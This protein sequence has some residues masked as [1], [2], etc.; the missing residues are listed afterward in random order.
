MGLSVRN[1]GIALLASVALGGCSNQSP[2]KLCASSSTFDQLTKIISQSIQG[3]PDYEFRALAERYGQPGSLSKRIKF[4]S[5]IVVAVNHDTGKVDCAALV[6]MEVPGH[7]A[8]S[9]AYG[10]GLVVNDS[11]DTQATFRV[12]YS[13][14]PAADGGQA[15]Y[16]LRSASDLGIMAVRAAVLKEEAQK[17][18]P[19]PEPVAPSGGATAASDTYSPEERRLISQASQA[20]ADFRD[21][22]QEAEKRHAAA[23]EQLLRR[24]VCW[25]KV[26]EPQVDYDFHRCTADSIQKQPG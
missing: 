4:Q 11:D 1:T 23:L 6:I 9:F 14:Q 12:G 5:P 3:A 7:E 17:Q 22:D 25:G 8:R 2:A 24:D 19:A 20:W 16:T 10:S 26:G 18:T 21:G 15:V 13:V